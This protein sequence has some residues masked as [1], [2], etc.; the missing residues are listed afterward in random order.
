MGAPVRHS[1]KLQ[2]VRELHLRLLTK[3]IKLLLPSPFSPLLMVVL[4]AAFADPWERVCGRRKF[5]KFELF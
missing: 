2:A 1:I 5:R 4:L 3:P